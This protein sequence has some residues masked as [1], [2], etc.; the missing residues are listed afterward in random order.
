MNLAAIISGVRPYWSNASTPLLCGGLYALI[1][2]RMAG[3]YVM[4]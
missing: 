1:K 4:Q 3:Y 2:V